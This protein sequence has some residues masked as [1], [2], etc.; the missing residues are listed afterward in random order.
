MAVCLYHP[1]RP[2]IGICVRCRVVICAACCTR[3]DGI[4]HCHSCLESLAQRPAVP[5]R[6]SSVLLTSLVL[7]VLWAALLSVFWVAQ[8]GLAP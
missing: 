6:P 7:A 2:G 4:N 8:G 1:D 5:R 3:L